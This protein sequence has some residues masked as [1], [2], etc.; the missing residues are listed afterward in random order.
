MPANGVKKTGRLR[1]QRIVH[2]PLREISGICLKRGREHRMTLVAVGDHAATVAWTRLPGADR[3]DLEWHT[4][5]I[6]RLPG[7]RLDAEDSQIEAICSDGA[8]RVLLLQETPPRAELVDAQEHR[9]VATIELSVDGRGDLADSWSDPDGSRGEGA[10]LLAG[11]HL[12]IAKEKNPR[13]LIEFGPPG[14]GS[15]G[16][17][18]GGALPD[19]DA[20]PIAEGQHRFVALA[21]WRPDRALRDACEDF[22]D[23]EIGPD[24]GLYVLSDQSASIARLDDLAPGGGTASLS[25]WWRLDDVEGKPEGLAFAADG[26]AIVALDKRKRKNNLVLLEPAIATPPR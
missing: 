10:A 12:L 5:D 14:A 26:R 7:S 15:R 1:V 23:L 22:S 20:W 9:V 25:A 4:I 18:A 19:G 17:A 24:G 8:G 3:G 16:L 21:V 11:G 2:A 6:A 13:V